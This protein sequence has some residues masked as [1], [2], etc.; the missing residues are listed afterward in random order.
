LLAASYTYSKSEIAFSSHVVKHRN[1]HSGILL[2]F[3]EVID[4]GSE[5]IA[6]KETGLPA[7]YTPPVIYLSVQST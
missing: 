1:R 5:K 6:P 7:A 2:G 4:N 3:S